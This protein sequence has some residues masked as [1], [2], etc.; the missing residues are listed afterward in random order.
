MKAPPALLAVLLLLSRE[1]GTSATADRRPSAALTIS[2]DLKDADLVD[3][4]RYFSDLTGLNLVLDPAVGG[5]VTLRL[6]DVPWD[7]AL[8]VVLAGN[9][10]GHRIEA[11]VLYVAPVS[12]LA[13][14]EAAEAALGEARET[15]AALSTVVF[16]LS[17][18][19]A[20]QVAEVL[21]RTVLS[22]R[23]SVV[24]DA[25]TN[26]LI[27]TDLESRLPTARA[28]VKRLDRR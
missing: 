14:R 2:L 21:R 26:R 10:L 1:P 9:G 13:A 19:E 8:G 4:L 7:T 11:N 16:R 27:L 5:R 22:R 25:R 12:V 23:G 28:A 6:V 18:A 17:Y 3:L 20:A 24:V 15:A